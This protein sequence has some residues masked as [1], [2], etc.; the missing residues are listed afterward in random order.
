MYCSTLLP[1]KTKS[2]N[3]KVNLSLD[4]SI[5]L[6]LNNTFTINSS[7]FWKQKC[8]F[9]LL[10]TSNYYVFEANVLEFIFIDY[11]GDFASLAVL[12]VWLLLNDILPVYESCSL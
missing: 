4:G 8:E 6:L 2:I 9:L 7:S 3:G 10:T 11:R 12:Q 5:L 1:E